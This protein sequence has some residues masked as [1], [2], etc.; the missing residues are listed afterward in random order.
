MRM[1]DNE[2]LCEEG[3]QLC[4]YRREEDGTNHF[5]CQVDPMTTVCPGQ[6]DESDD[7]QDRVCAED[8]EERAR[9]MVQEQLGVRGLR[10]F[11]VGCP[12]MTE[13]IWDL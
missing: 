1:E 10:A 4:V 5:V 8:L 7:F 12:D 2:I 3:G 11:S 9:R 6:G 13:F